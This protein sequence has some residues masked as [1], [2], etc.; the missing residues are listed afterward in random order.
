V[1]Q[2]SAWEPP[3]G[4]TADERPDLLDLGDGHYVRAAP[5]LLT[6]A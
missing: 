3:F 5:S 1:S 6:D 2:P 4:V